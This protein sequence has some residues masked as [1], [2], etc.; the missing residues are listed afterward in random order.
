[1][2]DNQQG[3]QAS[4]LDRLIDNEP[5]T[6]KPVQSYSFTIREIKASVVRELENI[7]N[8]RRN[9][10][11]PPIE[12]REI[13]N[14]VYVYGLR[15]FTS[16]D[17]RNPSVKQLLRN[18][19]EKTIARFERRLKNVSVHVET[20]EKGE[21]SIKFRITGLL[22]TDTVTEPVTFDAALDINRGDVVIAK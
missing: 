7:L 17:P 18:D 4:I 21:R 6:N 20:P 14:S 5:G 16:K 22:F 15:D 9:I 2:K 8:A 1:M 13:N 11:P 12:Y 10:L 3:I 19:V